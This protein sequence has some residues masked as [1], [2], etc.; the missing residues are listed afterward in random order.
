MTCIY[1]NKM[2]T[3][4]K[5]VSKDGETE[6]QEGQIPRARD[7]ARAVASQLWVPLILNKGLLICW[8]YFSIIILSETTVVLFVQKYQN[9]LR[10]KLAILICSLDIR[11]FGL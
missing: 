5:T 6:G 8:R 9:K 2:C 11:G 1:I 4:V 7:L 10:R 3:E